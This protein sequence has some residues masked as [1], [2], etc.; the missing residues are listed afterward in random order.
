MMR[1]LDA[2]AKAPPPQRAAVQTAALI[3][4]AYAGD[5]SPDQRGRIAALGVAEGRATAGRNLAL[6]AAAQETLVGETAMLA[7][8]TSADAG[9]AGLAPGD[10]ARIVQALRR[11]GLDAD[12]RNFAVEGLLASS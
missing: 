6:A 3:V 2:A 11:V 5:S 4:W 8:W 7:L 12:A 10:R 1:L 9:E